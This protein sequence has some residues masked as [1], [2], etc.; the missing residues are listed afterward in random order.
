MLATVSFD[1][2]FWPT[3]AALL[4]ILATVQVTSALRE[5]ETW[6]EAGDLVA[7][8]SY[9]A[10]GD[11]R[12]N[13]EHPPLAK[14]LSALP[15]VAFHLDFPVDEAA[16]R[17]GDIRNLGRAFLYHNRAWAE[18]ILFSARAV[19]IL[20]T[21]VLGALAAWWTRKEFGPLAALVAMVLLALDPNLI[22]HGRYV[23]SDLMVTL[24]IFA[25]CL[26]WHDYLTS[27]RTITLLA[28]GLLAGAAGMTKFS[29]LFLLPLFAL[30]Y[31]LRPARFELR[32]FLKS[33]AVV[34]L[35]VAAC[36][37]AA[38][39]PE[40]IHRPAEFSLVRGLAELRNKNSAGH[41]A[42]LLG[43]F[44]MRGWWY[45]FPVVF[46]VKSTTAVVF[47]TLAGIVGLARASW[48][49]IPFHWIA[50]LVP[51][52][53]YFAL[54]VAGHIDLGVRHLLP[55][56]PFLYVALGAAAAGFTRT[57]PRACLLGLVLA[58]HV[59]ESAAIYP[60]YLAFFNL[61]AGGPAQGPR[62]LLDSNI[63]WGQGV[64]EFRTYL[65]NHHLR[66]VCTCYFG[67]A[68][69]AWYR[70]PGRYLSPTLSDQE[71]ERVDC[72]AAVSVTPLYGLY[73]PRD[74]FRSLRRRT[75]MARIGYSIYLYDLRKPATP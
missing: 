66:N 63:D 54:C 31:L 46:A 27:G 22:A 68:D 24:L 7:G 70:M 73:L 21:L 39:A 47:L 6:D 62:Y 16:W 35:L 30:V 65:E 5:S 4:L 57:R 19:T 40:L 72:V 13:P 59:A 48:R 52:A 41:N 75:P 10:T 11:Y 14:L 55:V 17:A 2:A 34:G 74:T 28:S 12:L 23:T 64:V 9:L 43:H 45:F 50:I 15:L 69:F 3:V 33:L 38:Y 44:S 36:T 29:A 61:L 49:R 60:H 37:A 58:L 20:L 71:L 18:T 51:A 56:Y 53:V 1:R 26:A 32:H 8:Y 42:Y 67:N 25:A